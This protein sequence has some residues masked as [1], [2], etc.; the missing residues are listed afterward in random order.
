MKNNFGLVR[1]AGWAFPY[2]VNF[3]CDIGESFDRITENHRRSVKIKEMSN[4]ISR[5][6][7]NEKTTICSLERAYLSYSRDFIPEIRSSLTDLH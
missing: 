1:Y 2:M 5:R 7:C 3:R 6:C 4:L